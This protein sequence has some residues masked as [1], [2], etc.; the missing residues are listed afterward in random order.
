MIPY[1]KVKKINSLTNLNPIGFEAIYLDDPNK[2]IS[3]GV[4]T[5]QISVDNF[6]LF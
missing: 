6:E 1:A 4:L 3:I 5:L 2:N